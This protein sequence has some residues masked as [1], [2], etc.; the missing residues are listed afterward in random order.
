MD[1]NHPKA[2]YAIAVSYARMPE[3]DLKLA[4]EHFEISK[5]LGFMYP[6]WFEDF[7]KRLEAGERF[8]GQEGAA[9]Q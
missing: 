2:Q 6:Q 9:K 4:R 5:K 7:L 8:P 3:P 1:P